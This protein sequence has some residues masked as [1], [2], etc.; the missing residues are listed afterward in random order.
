MIKHPPIDASGQFIELEPRLSRKKPG[1][2][3]LALAMAAP[4]AD[5]TKL[6]EQLSK[7]I[8]EGDC[9]AAQSAFW[10]GAPW[11]APGDPRRNPLFWVCQN[12]GA[13]APAML[14]FFQRQGAWALGPAAFESGSHVFT[15]AIA[16]RCKQWE[17]AL[18][19][20][21]AASNAF[22]ERHR[23]LHDPAFGPE[24]PD[25]DGPPAMDP[26]MVEARGAEPL[27]QALREIFLMMDLD[28][29]SAH[30]HQHQISAFLRLALPQGAMARLDPSALEPLFSYRSDSGLGPLSL[31]AGLRS[32]GV[33]TALLQGGAARCPSLHSD[34][35]A[36]LRLLNE[37]ERPG[38]ALVFQRAGMNLDL[39]E[40]AAPPAPS[41]EPGPFSY[42]SMMRLDER[43]QE[44]RGAEP[45][46]A[47]PLPPAAPKHVKRRVLGG[48]APEAKPARP[49]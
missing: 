19:L 12:A 27:S 23:L 10:R 4:L 46:P 24:R 37:R 22:L 3:G 9:E 18:F 35:L 15:P 25:P 29:F 16:A 45:G 20:A 5:K 48:E 43:L 47:E 30:A 41:N 49:R 39:N 33:L 40:P 44:R 21:P 36:A 7:A 28:H 26:S 6:T 32:I 2:A 38:F 14:S 1:F 8:R 13:A 31:A 17:A 42:V 11:I 34:A